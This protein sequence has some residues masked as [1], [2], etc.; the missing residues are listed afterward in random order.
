[1]VVIFIKMEEMVAR[2]GEGVR[3]G[4]RA[5]CGENEAKLIG[6]ENI[7]SRNFTAKVQEANI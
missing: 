3:S 5:E 4:D 1:M 7:F 2:W 6:R